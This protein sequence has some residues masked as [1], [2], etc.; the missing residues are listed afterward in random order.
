MLGAPSVDA[1]MCGG[2]EVQAA[3]TQPPPVCLPGLPPSRLLPREPREGATATSGRV[4]RHSP[5]CRVT[6]PRRAGAAEA[7]SS[8]QRPLSEHT[9][10]GAGGAGAET[11]SKGRAPTECG[12]QQHWGV[13]CEQTSRG[14]ESMGSKARWLCRHFLCPPFAAAKEPITP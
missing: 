14:S 12:S 10:P 7:P 3:P 6:C 8:F 4:I 11:V 5:P 13:S 2:S 9:L 1:S